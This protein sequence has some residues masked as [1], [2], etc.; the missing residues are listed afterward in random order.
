MTEFD[1]TPPSSAQRDAIIA[2]LTAK[3]HDVLLEHGTEAAF[4]GS[5]S[6]TTRMASTRA[7][8]V[9]CLS[10]GRVRNSTG[11]DLRKAEYPRRSSPMT[12]A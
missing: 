5:F 12:L 8:F 11:V 9:V 6:T 3:E 2:G 1:L 4:C 7:A 10:F